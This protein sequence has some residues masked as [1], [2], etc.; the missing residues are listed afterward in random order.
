M[1]RDQATGPAVFRSKA[2]RQVMATTFVRSVAVLVFALA[3]HRP[4][5]IGQAEREPHNGVFALFDLGAHRRA[6]PSPP[7]FSPS[8]TRART[9]AAGSHILIPTAHCVAPTATTSTSSTRSTGGDSR[10]ASRCRSAATSI[11]KRSRATR[12]SW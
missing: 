8:R 9:R 10:R 4:E 6:D 12:F 11:Q 3:L 2:G 1:I 5:A 7:T